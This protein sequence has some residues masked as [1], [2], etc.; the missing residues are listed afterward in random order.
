MEVGASIRPAV[1]AVA[2]YGG[3]RH[4]DPEASPCGVGRK[5]TLRC[6]TDAMGREAP[7][8]AD[9]VPGPAT[10][11]GVLV[12]PRPL[13]GIRVVDY[14]HLLAG[15]NVGP[16]L[17]ALGDDVIKVER[18]GAG[19]PGR[20]NATVLDEGQSGYFLQLNMGKRESA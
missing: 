19:D 18:P 1:A 9:Q 10:A 15:P 16:C 17:V 14:C 12:Q 2:R 4:A 5:S 8:T 20:R 11:G 13:E 7:G 6:R 3:V